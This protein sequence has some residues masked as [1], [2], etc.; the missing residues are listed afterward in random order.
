MAALGV[1]ARTRPNS[2]M[3]GEDGHEIPPRAKELWQWIIIQRKRSQ[4]SLKVWHQGGPPCSRGWPHTQEGMRR[5]S[6]GRL[7]RE[8]EDEYGRRCQKA[9][10]DQ[11]T[12]YQLLK[13][14]KKVFETL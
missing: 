10:Y 14:I 3:K 11:N 6:W 9:K 4:V 12:L 5:Q 1:S 13:E 2:N 8:R 7:V